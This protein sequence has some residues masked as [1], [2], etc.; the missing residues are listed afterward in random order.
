MTPPRAKE[1][2][3]RLRA[4]KTIAEVNA[5]AR[6]VG[7]EVQDMAEHPTHSVHATHI[8]NLADYMRRFELADEV[9]RA[10]GQ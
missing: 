3:D 1:I 9:P 5:V 7:A 4:C 8:R 6:S 10:S 2:K